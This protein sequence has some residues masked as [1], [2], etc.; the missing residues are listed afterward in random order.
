MARGSAGSRRRRRRLGG[1]GPGLG[2]LPSSHSRGP[3]VPRHGPSAGGPTHSPPPPPPP[4]EGGAHKGKRGRGPA[5]R[6][7]GGVPR[8]REASEVRGCLALSAREGRSH[9]SLRSREIS[10]LTGPTL[11]ET[12]LRTRARPHGSAR[13]LALGGV[14]RV[15]GVPA[16]VQP[17]RTQLADLFCHAGIRCIHF[18]LK[19]E[20]EEFISSPPLF[21][22]PKY[23]PP[24]T[25]RM[26]SLPWHVGYPVLTHLGSTTPWN[27]EINLSNTNMDD[28]EPNTA[29]RMAVPS[30]QL[31]SQKLE[32]YLQPLPITHCYSQQA[33]SSI[34]LCSLP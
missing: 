13:V 5:G 17:R 29:W 33:T 6:R 18:T 34:A 20:K 7:R 1:T 28:L 15:P 8:G 21:S 23:P 31:Q 16:S 22:L 10:R 3:L 9:P 11:R 26:R 19:S 30:I 4:L 24:K 32:S 27:S 2:R 12:R 25:L 14:S